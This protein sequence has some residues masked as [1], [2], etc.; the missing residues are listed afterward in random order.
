MNQ[1][2]KAWTRLIWLLFISLAIIITLMIGKESVPESMWNLHT[3]TRLCV[4]V[5]FIDCSRRESFRTL[6][7]LALLRSMLPLQIR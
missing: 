6:L 1:L 2:W 7:K 5:D 4:L 3:L